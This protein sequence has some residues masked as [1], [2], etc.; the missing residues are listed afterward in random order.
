MSLVFFD[1]FQ[2]KFDESTFASVTMD[3]KE[4]C[5]YIEEEIHHGMPDPLGKSEHTTCFVDANHVSNV[6]TRS[7]PTGVLIYV[8]NV[9]IIWFS[10]M[11]NTVESSTVGSEFVSI[12]IARDLIV[13]LRYKLRMCVVPLDRL[14]YFMC[15]NQVVVNNT[16]LPIPTLV[17]KTI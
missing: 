13:A 10:N 9:P 5:V 1:T 6:V 7:F 2:S 17:K 12:W 8:M 4:S 3:W 14:S 16:S 11:H 15:D